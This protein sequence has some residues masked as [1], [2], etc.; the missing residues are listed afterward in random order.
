MSI[1]HYLKKEASIRLM[2]VLFV[3]FVAL[4]SYLIQSN[5]I[6]EGLILDY[7][8]QRQLQWGRHV[9]VSVKKLAI[10]LSS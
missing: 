3:L 9:C 4:N 8:L 10:M 5:L 6:E 2:T 1:I 7:S